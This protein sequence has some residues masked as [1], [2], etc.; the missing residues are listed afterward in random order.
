MTVVAVDKLVARLEDPHGVH[1]GVVDDAIDTL[2]ALETE[3]DNLLL[4]IER[5]TVV[6]EPESHEPVRKVHVIK[7]HGFPPTIAVRALDHTVTHECPV[8]GPTCSYHQPDGVDVEMA[9]MGIPSAIPGPDCE[10]D[11]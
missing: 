5:L 3:R 9:S 11:Q 7:R 10:V 2:R 8:C 1:V 6:P 4:D